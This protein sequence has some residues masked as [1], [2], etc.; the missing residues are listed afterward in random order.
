M[1]FIGNWG[2]KHITI[3]LMFYYY[4]LID[5]AKLKL[6]SIYFSHLQVI[7]GFSKKLFGGLNHICKFTVYI[8]VRFYTGCLKLYVIIYIVIVFQYERL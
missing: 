7:V 8:T 6:V 5:S 1:I 2:C 4:L 3:T